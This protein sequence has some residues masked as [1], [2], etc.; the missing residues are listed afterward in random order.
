MW[1]LGLQWIDSERNSAGKGTR[2][3]QK[4]V[5]SIERGRRDK[6]IG[7]TNRVGITNELLGRSRLRERTVPPKSVQSVVPCQEGGTQVE[8]LSN[9]KGGED[10]MLRGSSHQSFFVA[11][12]KRAISCLLK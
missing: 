5:L 8:D 12:L 9:G 11:W 7:D 6:I 2:R 10:P 3:D 4:I 1:G